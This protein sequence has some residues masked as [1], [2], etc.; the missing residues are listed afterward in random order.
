MCGI[1]GV[2]YTNPERV[3]ELAPLRA[4]G[5]ALSHRGPDG[6]GLW[7]SPGIGLVHRRLSIIDLA[8]GSQPL[9]NEDG[10][11]QVVFNGEIYNYLEL[12]EQL[13]ASG[14]HFRTRSDTEVLVHLYEEWG[15]EMLS[16]LRGMFAFALWD[17]RKQELFLA[18]DRVGIKPLYLFR[19]SGKVL[20]ASQPRAF[21]P[22]RDFSRDIDPDALEAYLTY[23]MVPGS[24]SI[25]RGVEK[26]PPGHSLT[27]MRDRLDAKPVS[28]WKLRFEPA[29]ASVEE[30]RDRI[31]EKLDE[32]VRQH[33]ISDVPVGAFL[34]GGVDS[35]V[36]VSRAARLTASPLHTFS[37]G[38][39]ESRF[40]ERPYAREVARRFGTVHHEA[41]IR[42]DAVSLLDEMSEFFDEP[43][44]DCSSIPMYLVSKL[45]RNTVKVVLSGDGGDEAFG[46]YPRYAHDLKEAKIRRWLPTWFRRCVLRPL[47][48]LWPE[49]NWLPKPLRAKTALTNLTLNSADAYANTLAYCR[50]PQRRKL[51]GRGTNSRRNGTP[52]GNEIVRG[53]RTAPEDD[54]VAGMLAADVNCILPDD[55]LVKVDRASMAHGVEV[56]PPFL[57]HQLLELAASIPSHFKIRAGS[58]K[59]IL[60]EAY[61][62][63][64]PA[65]SWDR[66]KQGFVM[67][68]D[69]WFRGPLGPVFR[70]RVLARGSPV[71]GFIHLPTAER[72]LLQHRR[73]SSR[74][75]QVLW[76]LLVLAVWAERYRYA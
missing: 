42:P 64:L 4:M 1:A 34:S 66:P 48:Q 70:D 69:D 40:C 45:A 22:D 53:Y 31:R 74:Q 16:H 58:E 20:F 52:V 43:F 33:L 27:L 23:G 60:K 29:E 54:P 49:A 67:P 68:I 19:T 41:I 62:S 28:Y 10:S 73:G 76:S 55:Y 71:E 21:F 6:A 5:D 30:W 18:R 50:M 14:H 26:L 2:F 63:E 72:L 15:A 17:G 75:G 12:R 9:A 44:A 65:T 61:R 36:I 24:R 57:D 39:E 25:F 3:P 37:I 8:G 56:R 7:V 35:S 46:G 32:T 51:L 59:W 47:S 38:F 13:V 11:V